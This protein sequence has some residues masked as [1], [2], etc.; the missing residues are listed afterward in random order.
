MTNK[1]NDRYSE[2]GYAYGTQPNDFLVASLHHLPPDGTVLCLAEGEGRNSV[3]LAGKGYQVTAV[4]SSGVGL[5]KAQELARERGVHLTTCV[6]DLA[7]YQLQPASLDVVI[8]VFCHLPPAL[9]R[10]VHRRVVAALRPGGVFLL[11]AYTPR[12]LQHGTGGPPVVEL[13]MELSELREELRGLNLIHAIEREREIYEGRL[14][15][16]TG[17]VVQVIAIK[18]EKDH[19]P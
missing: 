3:F 5:Q 17:A 4:D 2:P 18:E 7:D 16:G 14:H 1:W 8:S 11:E 19:R 12:Q 10:Q 9:R 6:A 13:L 15:T